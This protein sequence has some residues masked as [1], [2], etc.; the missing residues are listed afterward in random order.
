FEVM[1]ISDSIKLLIKDNVELSVLQA[2]AEKDGLSS[3]RQVAIRK[4]LEGITTYEEVIA[5]TVQ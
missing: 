4:M 3:L 5:M 2:A 1:E